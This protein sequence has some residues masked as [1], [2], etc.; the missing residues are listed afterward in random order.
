MPRTPDL[1]T[2]L[3]DNQAT[4]HREHWDNGVKGRHA[5]RRCIEP[6]HPW[7][8]MRAPWLTYPDLPANTAKDAT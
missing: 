8:E 4:Q 6:D 2:G 1:Y 7:R 5:H 3:F